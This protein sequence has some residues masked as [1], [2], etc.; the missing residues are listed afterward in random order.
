M[1]VLSINVPIRK[2]SGNL[3]NDPRINVLEKSLFPFMNSLDTIYAIFQQDNEHISKLTKNWFKIENTEVLDWLTKS[4]DL[5]PI[6]NLWAILSRR[7]SKINVN[8]K[9]EKL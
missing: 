9:I 8:L 2:K 7:V 3:F 5:N 6:E 4:P 1:C